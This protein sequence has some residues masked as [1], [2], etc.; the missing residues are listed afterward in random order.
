M[1]YQIFQKISLTF[2]V[3][4]RL[5]KQKECFSRFFRFFR[6]CDN[7]VPEQVTLAAISYF[8]QVFVFCELINKN[9]LKWFLLTMCKEHTFSSSAANLLQQKPSPIMFLIKKRKSADVTVQNP[10][11]SFQTVTFLNYGGVCLEFF[12]SVTS[13]PYLRKKQPSS[14]REHKVSIFISCLR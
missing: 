1:M 2:P 14:F 3:I 13:E 11:A 6:I 12:Q 7:P 4:R 9:V 5:F 8:G 10:I